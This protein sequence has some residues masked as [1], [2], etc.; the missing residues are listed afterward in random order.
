MDNL[1]IHG[2]KPFN[3]AV[4]H[5]GPG[6]RGEM[7]PVARELYP[8]AGVLEPLQT[9]SSVDG[10]V[11]ELKN[12]LESCGNPPLVLIGFSWG[13]WLSYILTACHPSLVKKLILVS[14]GPFEGKYAAKIMETRLSHLSEVEKQEALSLISAL[15]SNDINDNSFARFGELM[16]KAD[17]FDALSPEPLI[18]DD[19]SGVDIFQQVWRQ[20]RELRSSGE[21]LNLG[22]SI[23]CPVV[24]I[25]GDYDPHPAEGVGEP[26]SR[27]LKDFKFILLQKC[28]HHPW[29]ERNAR[30]DFYRI[31]R[32]EIGL[33]T[34][35]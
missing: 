5:G 7:Y 12:I 1:R 25:H 16:S 30:D 23:R 20:A 8:K 24:A 13:A 15:N 27:V 33:S 11:E 4:V 29:L 19:S 31:L 2:Q 9:E 18:S 10:Q 6:A 22:Q 21:L 34:N 28:G 17:S 32:N 35:S 3:I 26:L 14:S